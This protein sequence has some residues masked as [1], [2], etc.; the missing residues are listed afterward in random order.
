LMQIVSFHQSSGIDLL[1]WLCNLELKLQGIE[2]HASH[3]FE[4]HPDPF[5]LERVQAESVHLTNVDRKVERG[6]IS[7]DDGAR[8]LGYVKA[9]QKDEG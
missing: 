2:A 9:F 8:E 6:Y 4:D 1:N 5:R 3:R 7:K